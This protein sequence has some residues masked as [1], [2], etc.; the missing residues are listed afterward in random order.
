VI[1]RQSVVAAGLLAVSIAAPAVADGARKLK[2]AVVEGLSWESIA[3]DGMERQFGWYE[4]ENVGP[5]PAP[6][7]LILHGGGG[8]AAQVWSG[9]DGRGWRRLADRH[10][11]MLILPEGRSDPGD[12][13][14]HHWNDCRQG[15]LERDAASGADDVGFL[16][17]VVRWS[18]DHR[19][20]D[21][22]RVYVTGASNG[23][24]MSF[25]L[26]MEAPN[27]LA[28]AAPIIANLPNPSECRGPVR[29]LPILVMNGTV[30]PLM[31][32]AGGCVGLGGCRRGTVLSTDDTVATWIGINRTRPEPTCTD[33]PDVVPDDD[34]TVTVCTW[35]GG[36]AGT[37]ILLYRIDGGGHAVPGP[38]DPPLWYSLIVGPKNQDISA[39]DEIWAF[40]ERHRRIDAAPRRPTNRMHHPGQG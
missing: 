29:A 14:S 37:E 21:Q 10:G 26:A 17:A 32:W 5:G 12:P 38:D 27:L 6:L 20:V 30:D 9:D 19:A 25:R 1:V 16:R 7:V 13:D 34:S 28:A 11:L 40:F 18:R 2:P 39:A 35:S 22:D 4:G 23:G 36:V 3:H 31:P 24:M 33:L 15:I 8:R